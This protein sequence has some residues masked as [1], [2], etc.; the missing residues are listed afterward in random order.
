MHS[1]LAT[2]LTSMNDGTI[3]FEIRSVRVFGSTEMEIF[4]NVKILWIFRKF[5]FIALFTSSLDIFNKK[6]YVFNPW[7][8]NKKEGKGDKISVWIDTWFWR[9]DTFFITFY[10]HLLTW[11]CEN[12]NFVSFFV[13]FVILK[14]C[15][16][17]HRFKS[18]KLFFSL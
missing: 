17:T 4:Q 10:L 8:L 18:W 7:G 3:I 9:R 2:F 16:C 1:R 14:H 11:K 15:F 12:E 13:W 5:Y 6:I